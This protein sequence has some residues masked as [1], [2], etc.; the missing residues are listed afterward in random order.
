MGDQTCIICRYNIIVIM[1]YCLIACQKYLTR[2][3]HRTRA[4]WLEKRGLSYDDK[5][6]GI[7]VFSYLDWSTYSHAKNKILISQTDRRDIWRCFYS[8]EGL[9][10]TKP[11]YTLLLAR[12]LL[13]VFNEA[14]LYTT[15]VAKSP[16]AWKRR[17][18]S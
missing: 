6:S 10:L 14:T 7:K 17:V 12:T 18:N 4:K 1:L 5:S 9:W 3:C 16:K 8:S 13:D 11:D 2:P 15:A